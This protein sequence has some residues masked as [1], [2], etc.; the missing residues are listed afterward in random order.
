MD[1]YWRQSCLQN[2]AIKDNFSNMLRD[3]KCTGMCLKESK[4]GGGDGEKEV[5]E[6]CSMKED[7]MYEI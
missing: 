4:F 5:R 2:G 7:I 1:N 3:A 6:G